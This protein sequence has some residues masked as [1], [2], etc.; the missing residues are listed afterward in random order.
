[1]SESA[2]TIVPDASVILKWVLDSAAEPGHAAAG[3]LLGR[4][5]KGEIALAVPPLWVYEVGNVLCLK[6][7]DAADDRRYTLAA[8][9][10]G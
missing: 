10:G 4:W 3:L 5:R 9:G 1:M 8:G 7:P 2:P 6:R